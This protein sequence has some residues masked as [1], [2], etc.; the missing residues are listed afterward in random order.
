MRKLE[1]DIE[2]ESDNRLTLTR[3]TRIFSNKNYIISYIIS[4]ICILVSI[5][6]TIIMFHYRSLDYL[7]LL[8]VL[9]AFTFFLS[10]LWN[11]N[12]VKKLS[13]DKENQKIIYYKN[14]LKPHKVKEYP[15]K[16]LV[17]IKLI[18][19]KFR[20]GGIGGTTYYKI[21][22]SFK[23]NKLEIF[24]KLS[25]EQA[26]L[27]CN[28]LLKYLNIHFIGK[29]GLR[30]K[31]VITNKDFF[32]EFFYCLYCG[33]RIETEDKADYCEN[34][35]SKIRNKL[36]FKKLNILQ[37]HGVSLACPLN[38]EIYLIKKFLFKKRYWE[39]K[40]II[41]IV[42]CILHDIFLKIIFPYQIQPDDIS[43]KLYRIIANNIYRCEICG[44]S[45]V[46]KETIKKSRYFIFCIKCPTHGPQQRIVSPIFFPKIEE[47]CRNSR[48]T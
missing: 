42:K 25:K 3:D 14:Y 34:C 20:I 18:K 30:A 31:K 1:F 27:I 24:T 17:A 11:T 37:I 44:Q 28:A 19:Y 32:T 33:V 2:E 4:L 8:I 26:I 16:A 41:L 13:I 10:T 35:G 9:I 29:R 36:E 46:L 23:T 43:P 45:A 38:G 22:L 7:F 12:K 21:L 5:I 47:F 39:G 6:T 15:M 40:R 48:A